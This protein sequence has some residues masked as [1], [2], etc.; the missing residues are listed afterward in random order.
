MTISPKECSEKY[1]CCYMHR[2]IRNVKMK[3]QINAKVVVYKIDGTGGGKQVILLD[4][5]K[6]NQPTNKNIME[7]ENAGN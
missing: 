2:Q 4:K 5:T 3:L 6:L 7:S 1:T